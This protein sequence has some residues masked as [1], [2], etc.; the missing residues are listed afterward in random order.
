MPRCW[1]AVSGQDEEV[2]RRESLKDPIRERRQFAWRAAAA[3][4]VV[5]VVYLGVLGRLVDL[6]VFEHARYVGL[7]QDNRVHIVALPPPRGLIYDR[8]GTLLAE[9]VPSYALEVTPEQVPDMEATL[10]ALADVVALGPNDIRRF[11]AEMRAKWPFKSITLRFNLTP[12]EV[13]RF[14]VQRYRFPGVDIAARLRRHYPFGSAMV[15]AVGYV[16]QIDIR[17]LQSVDARNYEGTSHY[18]KTGVENFYETRLHGKVGYERIEVNARGRP[19]R[20]LERQP[21]VPGEDLVLSLD[22]GLQQVALRALAGR[23][24][25][26]VAIDPRNG[27]VLA[28]VSSPS[29]DPNWFV[30]GISS[31]RYNALREN[32]FRPLFNRALAGQYPPA[33][34]IKPFMAL[35][36]MQYGIVKPDEPLPAGPYWRIPGDP[37]ARKYLDWRASGH[38]MTAVAKAIAESVDTYFYP[39]AY[40]LGIDDM[41]RFLSRFGLGKPTGID[42]VGALSGLL[43]SREWKRRARGQM[44]YPGNTVVAGIGQGFM[45]TTPLQLASATATLSMRGKGFRPHLLRATHNPRSGA[46]T[47]LPS[48]PLAPVTLHSSRYWAAVI[49]GMKQVT[50]QRN[51]TAWAVFRDFPYTVGGKTGTA[52][53]TSQLY[54]T[55]TDEASIPYKLRDNGL[56]IAFA[57]AEHPLI[58]VAVVVEHN[59]GGSRSAA[60][61]AREMIGYY[62]KHNALDAN[63]QVTFKPNAP[64]DLRLQPSQSSGA[65]GDPSRVVKHAAQ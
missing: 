27:D 8:H 45:L 31:A 17:E 9:N 46:I 65:A 29:Y 4:L 11:K 54:N 16:G 60:P 22:A 33:S 12:A 59:G 38:G 62:L 30:D 18:G 50:Q 24:G 2:L 48:T 56:F 25:A 21:P 49:T 32:A 41:H 55:R 6:Q 43:P 28:L 37:A 64:Q 14:A 58:A 40:K 61:V 42:T 10:A 15:D 52:Q 35:A 20:V 36:G 7:A 34:T 3:G 44:W 23:A 57:P 13:S 47:A 51:G 19:I 1:S 5:L 26:A 39:L 63:G 53:V